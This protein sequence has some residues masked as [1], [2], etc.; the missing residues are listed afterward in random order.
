MTKRITSFFALTTFVFAVT[1]RERRCQLW[2]RDDRL[3]RCPC[4]GDD[5]GGPCDHHSR[6][7]RLRHNVSWWI[8]RWWPNRL[9]LAVFPPKLSWDLR[10]TFRALSKETAIL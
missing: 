3:Q 4:Y 8:H 2:P 5:L 6:R 1:W 10:P 7:C 9:Q